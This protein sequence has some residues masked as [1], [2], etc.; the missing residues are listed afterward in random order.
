MQLHE[1]PRHI[2]QNLYRIMQVLKWLSL[3]LDDINPAAYCLHD[4]SHHQLNE[5]ILCTDT[6]QNA[7]RMRYW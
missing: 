1:W 4:Q 5:R 7:E 6:P 3:M 2:Q